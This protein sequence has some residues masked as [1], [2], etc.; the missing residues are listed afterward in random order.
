M[1]NGSELQVVLFIQEIIFK[2]SNNN[3]VLLSFSSPILH[4]RIDFLLF[5]QFTQAPGYDVPFAN[6]GILSMEED[7]FSGE[8]EQVGMIIYIKYI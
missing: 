7:E 1:G 5:A 2:R 3:H 8:D 6:N 4:D